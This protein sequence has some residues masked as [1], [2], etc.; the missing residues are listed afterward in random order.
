M[1]IKLLTIF[2]DIRAWAE[3]R[4][5]LE[6]YCD[7]LSGLCARTT[8][9]LYVILKKSGYTPLIGYSDIFHFY[10]ILG[11]KIVDLTATQFDEDWKPINVVHLESRRPEYRRT[12]VF[13]NLFR[14]MRFMHSISWYEEQIPSWRDLQGIY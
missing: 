10:I 14:A 12:Q 7:D 3:E 11:G 9:R 1:D 4:A 6:D 13:P 8:A 2:R 5:E